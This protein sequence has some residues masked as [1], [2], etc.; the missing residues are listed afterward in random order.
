M[1]HLFRGRFVVRPYSA[2]MTAAATTTKMI[3]TT[4]GVGSPED[5]SGI[6]RAVVRNL[7]A[8]IGVDAGA[9]VG[10]VD[11]AWEIGRHS[12]LCVAARRAVAAGGSVRA[13]YVRWPVWTGDAGGDGLLG[14]RW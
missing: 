5:A 9:A 3:S 7:V 13:S 14:A 1:A 2:I 10:A 8:E 6:A 11:G 4:S 12:W